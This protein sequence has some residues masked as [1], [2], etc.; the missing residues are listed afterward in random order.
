MGPDLSHKHSHPATAMVTM[1]PDEIARMQGAQAKRKAPAPAP[2]P[3]PA[4][5]ADRPLAHLPINF[6][7][8]DVS[9]QFQAFLKAKEEEAAVR[10]ASAAEPAHQHRPEPAAEPA[11]AAQPKV[12][13]EESAGSTISCAS[14]V[15]ADS[16]ILSIDA[17]AEEPATQ[18]PAKP[19]HAARQDPEGARIEY[20]PRWWELKD[21]PK[22]QLDSTQPSLAEVFKLGLR[23]GATCLPRQTSLRHLPAIAASQAA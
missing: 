21:V 15:S 5:D 7:C 12:Q 14:T 1:T 3:G 9:A 18:A 17:E 19:S 8:G 22:A 11:A 20:A 6:L 10:V 4:A 2:P 13:A 23:P 16:I